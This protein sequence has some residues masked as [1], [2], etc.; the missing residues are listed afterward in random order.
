MYPTLGRALVELVLQRQGVAVTQRQLNVRQGQSHLAQVVEAGGPIGERIGH[1]LLPGRPA[2]RLHRAYTVQ[3]GRL[4]VPL[5]L[6]GGV[7]FRAFLARQLQ[8]FVLVDRLHDEMVDHL[9]G[10]AVEEALLVGGELGEVGERIGVGARH[11]ARPLG[12]VAALIALQRH[13]LDRDED[14]KCRLCNKY[15]CFL[16]WNLKKIYGG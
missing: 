2:G 1:R 11:L 16:S 15:Y 7:A 4:A 12:E 5:L 13:L 14:T 6:K 3:Q 9:E 8:V 10:G